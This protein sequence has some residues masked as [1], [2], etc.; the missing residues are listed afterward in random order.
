MA[1]PWLLSDA[2]NAGAAKAQARSRPDLDTLA[3]LTGHLGNKRIGVMTGADTDKITQR[4]FPTSERVCYPD[5]LA[6]IAAMKS[7][8]IEAF[9]YDESTLLDYQ[10]TEP[11]I[12]VPLYA[13]PKGITRLC[14]PRRGRALADQLNAFL[15]AA[16][17][18][19]TLA[20]IKTKWFQTDESLWTIDRSGLTGEKG[21]L[22]VASD[23][24]NEPFE[25]TKDIKPVGLTI[26]LLTRFARENGYALEYDY[27]EFSGP[28]PVLVTGGADIGANSIFPAI[29]PAEY[30]G[31]VTRAPAQAADHINIPHGTNIVEA[32]YGD[33][34]LVPQ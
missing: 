1:N 10:P 29:R 9:L 34:V 12:A 18:N 2:V 15:E 27:I 31:K 4:V 25:M 30:A 3:G 11:S 20:A 28:I 22:R 8:K 5:L 19:D 24:N 7:G 17:A 32:E 26:D 6:L 33:C 16:M 21:T 13:F 23:M 14:C